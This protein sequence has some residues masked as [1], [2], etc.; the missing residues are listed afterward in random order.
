MFKTF[1][2]HPKKKQ[3]FAFYSEVDARASILVRC[4]NVG[5]PRDARWLHFHRT[6]DDVGN[7]QA[8]CKECNKSLAGNV[9]R[10]IAHVASCDKRKVDEAEI[11]DTSNAPDSVSASSSMTNMELSQQLSSPSGFTST[12]KKKVCQLASG[13]EILLHATAAKRNCLCY[14]PTLT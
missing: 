6:K 14:T 1:L 10:M 3:K 8:V 11:G 2:K 4:M 13:F 5:R 9:R 12:P 7:P